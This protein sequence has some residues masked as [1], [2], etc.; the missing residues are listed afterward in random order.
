MENCY[1]SKHDL[2]AMA[3]FLH[4]AAW[5][6]LTWYTNIILSVFVHVC[7]RVFVRVFVSVFVRVFV[8]VFVHVCMSVCECE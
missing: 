4:F 1:H 6:T 7:V 2:E 5:F 8:H 3:H